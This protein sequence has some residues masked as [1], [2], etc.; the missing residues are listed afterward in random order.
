MTHLLVGVVMLLFACSP[1]D[2]TP[3]PPPSKP[4]IVFILADDLGWH[5]VGYH[6]SEIKTPTIDRLAESGVRLEQFYTTS[7]CSPTRAS[8][9]T[10]RYTMRYGFQEG[11]VLPWAEYG[12][13]TTERMLSQALKDAG[14][15]TSICG[16]WHLGHNDP[17]YIPTH[18]GFDH[19]YGCYNG[20][21]DYYTH[22]RDEGLDWQRDD[23]PLEETGYATNLIAREAIRVIE[24][25]DRS[26]P[27]FLYVAFTAPHQPLEAPAQYVQQYGQ[28]SYL[29]RRRYAAMVTCMDDAIADIL[30]ALEKRGMKERTIVLF[31][32]D[33][34]GELHIGDN[35]PFRG[36][37][38]ELYEGGIRVPAVVNWPGIL[39]PR[40]VN[41]P[42][43]IADIYPTLLALAGAPSRQDP[44]LD[45]LDVWK[46]I[47]EGTAPA[48]KEMLLEVSP[49][50]GALLAGEWKL[51]YN[52]HL[53]GLETAKRG[54]DRYE[55]FN[56]KADPGEEQNL[57]QRSPEITSRLKERLEAYA[58]QSVP[59]FYTSIETPPGYRAP[60]YWARFGDEK[61]Q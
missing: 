23:R 53:N 54:P 8:L 32:S 44:P 37:K 35:Q 61:K 33:N 48:R 29:P 41:E 52:G 58:A 26:V 42:L 47:S 57:A 2:G 18:R 22:M 24:A 9:M 10:G 15:T 4:N 5:D 25:Q 45:G 50:R 20:A 55:L 7:L 38:G 16:K 1:T 40:V 46:T 14:Y 49:I 34:G 43:N 59:P 17:K 60:K 11:L 39:E 36:G 3:N 28:I 13:P 19:A 12:L 30:K 31:I 51:V 27:L 21:I 6:G 56:L